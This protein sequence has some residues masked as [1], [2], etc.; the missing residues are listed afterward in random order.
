MTDTIWPP[1]FENIRE[2]KYIVLIQSLR[3]AIRSGELEVGFKLPP[4]RE[5]AWQLGI[6][7]G[8]VARAYKLAVE[9]GLV[10]TTVGRGTFVSAGGRAEPV[11]EESLVAVYQD[12]DLNFR[13]V[14][15]PDV[16]Q[17]ASVRRIMRQ[18][19]GEIG[20]SYVDCPT[21]QRDLAARQA[22]V[23]W[24]GPDR[25]GR[26]TA[27]D[28]VLGLGAQHSVIM[29][30]QACLYGPNPV[31]LTEELGYPGIRHAARLL[32]AQ[33]VGVKM[34]Q[35]GMRPDLLEEALRTHGGQVL[36]TVAETH[37]PTTIRAT[38]SRRQQIA[39]LARQ[40]QLQIIEDDCYSITRPDH[41]TYRAIIPE[42]SWYVSS[43]T[44]SVSAALRFGYVACAT[45]QA[46]V[47]RQVSQSSFYGLPVPVLDIC[48]ELLNSGEAERLRRLTTAHTEELVK[49]AVNILGKWDIR[50]RKDVP[51]L[52][53]RLPQGWRGST[54]TAAC[55]AEKI[56][57]KSADEF[58]LSDGQAPNAVR[59]GLNPQLS[60]ADFE[61]ALRRI[62]EMLENPPV[63]VDI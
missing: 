62:S 15:L 52:W 29:T 54:F 25:V 31:I 56:G 16:G 1:S 51:F 38:G 53:L 28:I 9:E 2:S 21:P 17:D 12:T 42:R 63:S 26:L 58:A 3:G 10:E 44:K 35:D 60:D 8:T 46:A 23:D 30:L 43:L 50:W 13:G 5:L 33:V 61:R 27:D 20:E 22:V 37:S 39:D 55:A 41:P 7:P 34:D 59:I 32:R 14:K 47:A 40:Y 11:V 24:I 19:G 36:V 18:L 45:G 49:R 48:T 4:V 6:T 57:I